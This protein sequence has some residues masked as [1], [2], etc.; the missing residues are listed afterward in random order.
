[1][2]LA[3]ERVDQG[4]V[5]LAAELF[6]DTVASLGQ[7]AERYVGVGG[8]GWGLAVG[9]RVGVRVGGGGG[10]V[11]IRRDKVRKVALLTRP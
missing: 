8:W 3:R 9:V 7:R 10:R 2:A 1:M 6:Q 11:K 5:T 4:Y